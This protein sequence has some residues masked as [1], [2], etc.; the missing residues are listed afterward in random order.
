MNICAEAGF[1]DTTQLYDTFEAVC[2]V[3]KKFA[4][5]TKTEIEARMEE[6]HERYE[7][8]RAKRMKARALRRSEG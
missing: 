3:L 6:V 7:K 4:E 5:N 1:A 8:L 2:D